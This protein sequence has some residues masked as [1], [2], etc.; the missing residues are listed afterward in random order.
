[1]KVFFKRYWLWIVSVFLILLF[2][3]L[4][5]QRKA[6]AENKY[7]KAKLELFKAAADRDT[8]RIKEVIDSLKMK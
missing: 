3:I 7:T 4:F 8:E 6:I 1:M 2:S 5:W